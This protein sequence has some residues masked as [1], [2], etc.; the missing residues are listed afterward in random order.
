MTRPV[1]SARDLGRL[2]CALPLCSPAHGCWPAGRNR[3]DG[4]K[5]GKARKVWGES[6]TQSLAQERTFA[7]TTH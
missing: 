7:E 3:G 5:N 6:K 1:A 4:I 2:G